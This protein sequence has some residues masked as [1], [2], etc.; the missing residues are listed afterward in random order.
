[1]Q[2]KIDDKIAKHWLYVLFGLVLFMLLV[3]NGLSL[4]DQDESAYAGFGKR[5][6]ESGDWLVPEFPWS[7]VHRKTPFHFWNISFF[8]SIFGISEFTMRLSSVLYVFGTMLLLFFN[9]RKYIGERTAVASVI[10][11][12]SSYL[13]P[14]L[15]KVAVTD[16]TLLF[17]STLCAVSVIHVLLDFKWKWVVL[18]WISFAFA[19]L[20]KG[21]PVIIFT[22]GLAGL[23][24]LFSPNRW[25]L[26][27]F[28]PWFGLPLACLPLYFWG[29]RLCNLMEEYSLT[30][31]MNGMS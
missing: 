19:L 9:L 22:G 14:T 12:A 29:K 20:T 3:N 6:V 23:I 21:P 15:A 31:C 27:K 10:I 13:V 30:G 7:D 25:K 26:L 16:A 8:Y 17:F 18:F 2:N 4:W 11:L 5:M 24:L 28:H 1:M